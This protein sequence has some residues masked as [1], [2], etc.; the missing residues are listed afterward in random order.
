MSSPTPK[1]TASWTAL[2]CAGALALSTC[3]VVPLVLMGSRQKQRAALVGASAVQLGVSDSTRWRAVE[4]RAAEYAISAGAQ[5]VGEAR[6]PADDGERIGAVAPA[7][8][9]IEHGPA[10]VLLFRRAELMAL[11]SPGDSRPLWIALDAEAALLAL[12]LG[13]SAQNEDGDP[14]ARVFCEDLDAARTLLRAL[15]QKP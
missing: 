1:Q 4:V 11:R 5:G 10:L 13:A 7:Q 6:S 12:P 15:G 8:A 2:G 9:W 14:L 3:A